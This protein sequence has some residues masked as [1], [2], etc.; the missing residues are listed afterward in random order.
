M[1]VRVLGCYGSQMPGFNTTGFLLNGNILVDAGTVTS[2]LDITE[3]MNIDY[4]L[5]THPHLDHVRDIMFLADN[6]NLHSRRKLPITVIS[7]AAILDVLK[8][9]LF[10]NVIW[11]DFSIIPSPQNPVI[12]FR[13]IKPEERF[14]INGLSVRAVM[15]NHTIETVGYVIEFPEC[16]LI[17]MG[18]TGPT[19]RIWQIAG[20]V[21]NL[22]ALFIETSFHEGMEDIA[23]LSGHLTPITLRNELKKLGNL[24]TEIYLFHMK[25]L[26]DLNAI[27]KTISNIG[28]RNIH[29]LNDG[30][31]LKF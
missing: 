20:E 6:V 5:V 12:R 1:E 9:H 3:Q 19:E 30:D 14:E 29:I 21:K 8:K 13:K 28:N 4:I 11:P 23:S 17:F 2:V 24:D 7:T 15:M 22:K 18:D 16:S 26:Y 31:V 25:P 10:N 27:R